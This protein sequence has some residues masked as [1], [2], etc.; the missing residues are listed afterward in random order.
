MRRRTRPSEP[1]HRNDTLF[2]LSF[3]FH[4][5]L[6]FEI[7]TPFISSSPVLISLS[8]TSPML[9]PFLFTLHICCVFRIFQQGT[10]SLIGIPYPLYPL[11]VVCKFY[12]TLFPLYT[13][14][15]SSSDS[16]F[17]LCEIEHGLFMS[18]HR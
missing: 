10:V 2:S 9:Y 4:P 5:I 11:C 1:Y 18:Q 13:F 8:Y 7:R 17:E 15:I 3:C 14:F 16:T 12:I 6:S